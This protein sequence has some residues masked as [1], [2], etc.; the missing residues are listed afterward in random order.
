[1]PGARA[2]FFSAVPARIGFAM[3]SL[4]LLWLVRWGTGSYA[5]AGIVTGLFAVTSA[6]A[7]PVFGRLAARF[8]QGQVL[9]PTVLLHVGAIGVVVAVVALHCPLW[10]IALFGVLAGA[11]QPQ[12]SSLT[13]TRWSVLLAG[14]SALPT[15][16]ALESLSN[17]LA[18]L[19][20]PALVGTVSAV[21]VAP[22]GAVL[23]AALM[24]VGCLALARQRATEPERSTARQE[25]SAG[26]VGRAFGA[27]AL[28]NLGI[29]FFFGALQVSVTAFATARGVAGS[30]GLIYSLL[31]I[32]SLA[33]GFG[34]GAR[35]WRMSAPRQLV[36]ALAVLTAGSVPMLF[37]DTPSLLAL[38]LLLPGFGL[39]PSMIV[40]TL[41]TERVVPKPALTRA[42]AWLNSA[43]AVGTALASA[44]AGRAVDAH[45]AGWGFAIAVGAVGVATVVGMVAA[46]R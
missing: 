46:R 8:G 15:A 9:V 26:R 12:V 36:V 23:A 40:V 27:L 1:V 41:L 2:F 5:A 13:A 7:A 4:G 22:A 11:A 38:A 25:V 10:M 16:F 21:F 19:F 3:T 18:Y 6:L 33:A 29:G 28:V 37:A 31:S 39:A 45:G 32:T 20:G 30:A 14:S 44:I 17:E 42:F 24:L 43:G 34:Y 35:K